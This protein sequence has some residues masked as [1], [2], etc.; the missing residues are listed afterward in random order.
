VAIRSV[1]RALGAHALGPPVHRSTHYGEFHRRTRPPAWVAT[2][3]EFHTEKGASSRYMYRRRMQGWCLRG[4][5]WS[6]MSEG[7]RRQVL[8]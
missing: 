7:A 8:R 1:E 6:K 3:D 5:R 4:L 2:R